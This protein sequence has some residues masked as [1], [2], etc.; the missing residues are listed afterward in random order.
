MYGSQIRGTWKASAWYQ[1]KE[2][3]RLLREARSTTDRDT[4]AK[5]EAE[6]EAEAA[7]A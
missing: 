6:A 5:L 1:D 7:K 2:V 4:R 3:D